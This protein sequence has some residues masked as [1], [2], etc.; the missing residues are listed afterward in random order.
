MPSNFIWYELMTTDLDAAQAFY[1]NVVGWDTESWDGAGT[2][3][4]LLKPTGS[5][6]GIG[7]MMTLPAEAAAMGAPSMWVGY[8]YADDVDART[9]SIRAAGGS[10]Q[11]EPAD[12]PEVGRFSVVSDP[13]GAM[14]MLL[15]PRGE[16]LPPLAMSVLGNVGWR[17]LYAGDGATALDFY[18][19][20]FGWTKGEAL[21]MGSMGTYQ[22]FHA[23]SDEAAGGI[24][25]KPAEMPV[26]AWIFYFVVGNIDDA[27]S[28]VEAGGGKIINGP[29]EV[30]GGAWV[31]QAVDPQGAM[32]AL[33]GNR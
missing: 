18:T 25:T 12:I 24:M 15:A 3:Y 5:D 27:V 32:F 21:D 14:F 2:R 4:V 29:M 28:R 23:G 16:N 22:L 1:K 13:Q 31:V 9:E 8:V 11:R 6:R 7:G 19:R 20:Q 17:E 33:V 30:P 26:P 10:V